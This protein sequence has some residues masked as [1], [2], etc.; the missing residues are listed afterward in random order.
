MEDGVD[1]ENVHIEAV[2]DMHSGGLWEPAT[3]EDNRLGICCWC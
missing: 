3:K 2:D 1:P